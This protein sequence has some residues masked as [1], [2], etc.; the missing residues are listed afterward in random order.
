MGSEVMVVVLRK[1][2]VELCN[3]NV[4]PGLESSELTHVPASGPDEK[5]RGGGGGDRGALVARD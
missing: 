1:P 2:G 3:K 4:R 5:T